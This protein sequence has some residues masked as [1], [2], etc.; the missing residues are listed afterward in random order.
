MKIEQ[1]QAG[2]DP[3]RGSAVKIPELWKPNVAE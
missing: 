1:R 3:R 2:D